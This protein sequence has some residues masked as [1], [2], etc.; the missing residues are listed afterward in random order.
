MRIVLACLAA[1]AAAVAQAQD[2]EKRSPLPEHLPLRTEACFGRVYD[3]KHLAAHPKQRVTS[4]HL[5][6][7][8]SSDLNA[9]EEPLPP[10]QLL[11]ADGEYSHV[12]V[13][14]Y[15]RFRDRPGVF[16]NGLNCLRGN[17]GSVRCGV[18]CDGGSFKLKAAGR[19]SVLLEN[20]GFVVV[21]GC[22]ASEDEREQEEFVRPGADDRV[23][24]LDKKPVSV[25]LGERAA[26]APAWA[27]LGAPLRARFAARPVVCF[28]RTYDAAHLAAHPA[29]YVRRIA[30]QKDEASKADP[31]QV[32]YE[33]TFR[34]E[35]KDGKKFEKRTTCAPDKYAFACTT[36][37][38]MDEQRDFY[39]TR[40]SS[41]NMMLRD[42][43]GTLS[44]L[45]E[46]QLGADDRFFR[47]QESAIEA[48]KF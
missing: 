44:K 28:N 24:R 32:Y 43:H 3:A 9:E 11:D 27:K 6:R 46:T 21:G 26:L 1:L 7:G 19:D 17:D 40:A 12:L 4:F 23:F 5:A 30:V 25:C 37:T 18:D 35:G 14:A 48:C 31:N 47:L 29:Q 39:L 13:T 20:E 10:E 16:S 22:G 33:L 2:G 36:D 34:I 42:K 38:A 41:G 8:F 45:F 15:V